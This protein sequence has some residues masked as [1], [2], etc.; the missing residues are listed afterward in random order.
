[1]RTLVLSV[2]A[3]ILVGCSSAP[4]AVE[5]KP[6][7]ER[8]AAPEFALK[9]ANGTTVRVADY[10]GK[11]VV[12]NFWA[13]WCGPCKVEIPWFIDFEKTYKDRDFA[14]V[15]ISLDEEGWPVVKPYLE[16]KKINYRVLIGNDQ[17]SQLYGVV[18]PRLN[19][20]VDQLPTT[21]ILDRKGRIASVHIGL[22][23]KRDYVAEIEKLLEAPKDDSKRTGQR[24]IRSEFALIRPN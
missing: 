5:V 11:V 8:K 17:L 13:T 15:G 12:L 22:V 3:A 18:D 14:V 16:Q 19:G 20:G 24:S 1:M 7:G 4:K 2:L 23:P 6:E 21:M 9:D 10:K